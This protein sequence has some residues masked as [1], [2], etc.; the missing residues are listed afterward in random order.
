[1]M[2]PGSGNTDE[3]IQINRIEFIDLSRDKSMNRIQDLVDGMPMGGELVVK[4]SCPT[5]APDPFYCIVSVTHEDGPQVFRAVHP[6]NLAYPDTAFPYILADIVRSA[7]NEY[8][9]ALKRK[10][11]SS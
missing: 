4:V 2:T 8:R 3:Q 9:A 5:S 1:M 11:K 7:T 10:A 6:I